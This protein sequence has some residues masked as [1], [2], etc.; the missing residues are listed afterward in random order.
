MAQTDQSFVVFLIGM[1]VNHPWQFRKWLQVARAMPAMLQE[2]HRHP[3]LGFLGAE[4]FFRLF[5]LATFMISYWESYEHL[6]N[7]A[8]SRDRAHLPA[9]QRFNKTVG[10]DSSVGIWHE[11]YFVEAGQHESIYVGMPKFGLAKVMNHVPVR[12]HHG[13]A[14]Q[15][16]QAVESI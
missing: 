2:L 5:P 3:E 9:W 7:Y 1:R 6:E 15:R 10:T 12:G 13:R 14:R 8:R 11:T 16:L 4:Q